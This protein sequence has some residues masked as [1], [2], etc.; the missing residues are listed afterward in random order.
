VKRNLL[1]VAVVAIVLIGGGLFFLTQK[2]STQNKNEGT[3]TPQAVKTPEIAEVSLTSSGF[4]P[5]TVTINVGESVRWENKSGKD[6]SVNSDDHPNHRKYSF[7][8]L[9]LFTNGSSVQSA[10]KKAGTYTYHNH[11]LPQQ[12]GTVIVK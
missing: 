6:G 1:I 11:L 9:G 5:A 8:N 3:K 12:K 4:S 7:L 10:F 2:N